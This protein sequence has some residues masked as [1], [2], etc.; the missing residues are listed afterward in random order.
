MYAAISP[1]EAVLPKFGPETAAVALPVHGIGT[2]GFAVKDGTTRLKDLYQQDPVRV[3]FPTPPR[4]EIPAAAFVT[5]SGGLVGGDVLALGAAVE[6][7]A[8]AQVTAQA[9]EKIYRSNGGFCRIDLRLRV[10][11]GGWLEWLPQE[12][13]LFEGARMKRRTIADVSAGGRLMAGEFVVLGRGA[14]GEALTHGLVRDD[15]EV[16]RCGRSI[17]ADALCLDGDIAAITHHPA[18]LDGARAV[19]TAV[20][21]ADDAADYLETARDLLASTDNGV[22]TGATVVNG[23]LIARFLGEDPFDVRKAY[24]TFWASFRQEAAGLPARLPRLWHI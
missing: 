13:I 15:W 11:E 1:S 17:W 3:L 5:T 9:A 14:M 21:V 12:T 10:K 8:M 16:R 20:Y 24:G 23:L 2:V 22:R 6:A 18:G 7:E 4:G 19:A